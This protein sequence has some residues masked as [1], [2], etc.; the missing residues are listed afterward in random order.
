[1]EEGLLLVRESH[2]KKRK[3][4]ILE[5]MKRVSYI[6][7]PMVAVLLSQYLH[8]VVTQMMAGHLGELY[9]SS[10]A[11]A[12]SLSTVTGYSFLM[13]MASALETISGQAYGAQQYKKLG[14]QTYT[15]IFSLALVC[16]PISILWINMGQVLVFI[17]QDPSIAHEAGRFSTCLV[18]GLFAYAILQPLNRYF[19]VQS[20]VMPMVLSSCT[21]LCIHIL[22]CWL[23][24]YKS[25]LKN[26]GAAI[27]MSICIWLNAI[28]LALFM[29]FSP[30]CEAT[31]SPLSMEIFH[32]IAEFFRFAIP[33]A[34]MTCLGW[35]SLELQIL[36]SGLLPN[37]ELETSV[38]SVCLTTTSTLFSMPYGIGA[39]A[40]TRVSNELG[41]GNSQ[42][43][44]TAAGAAMIFAAANG[45]IV[46]S[47]LFGTRRV[48]GYCFSSEKEVIDYVT[49][50]APL[51]CVNV[52]LDSLQGGLSGIA[53]GCGWQHIGAGV[54]LAAFYLI[55]IP[56][57]AILGFW[58]QMRGRGLWIGIICGAIVQFALLAI[59]T[60]CTNWE[61]QA[62]KARERLS[63]S[64]FKVVDGANVDERL[65][66]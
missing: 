52:I 37:P 2:E 48:F 64:N 39:A 42:R 5:E 56:I 33:S 58:L 22:L 45:L 35:W 7:G 14:T 17:G 4:I 20:L 34:T 50:L 40:S 15:A 21:S 26:L 19:Q 49:T 29:K 65:L 38:L 1:M 27:S 55:G 30:S 12:I 6:A 41:A 10:T 66:N 46:S 36:L 53:R 25:S 59:I 60:G 23:L 24:V 57:S 47:V 44:R 62:N 13:G 43:A 16:I 9:L 63:E 54:N 3:I 8:Q 32:G 51:V 31:R 11:L 28:F 61:K 18:P